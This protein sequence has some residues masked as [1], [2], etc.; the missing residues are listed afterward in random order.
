VLSESALYDEEY[1]TA[2]TQYDPQ[3]ANIL[4]D[5][6]GL[7]ERDKHGVRL[8][9]DGQPANITI[10]SAGE[11]TL[12]TDVLELRSVIFFAVEFLVAM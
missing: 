2:W 8:L 3:Q 4:L 11:S 9:S 10:E 6:A 7:L 1:A 12:E 5:E